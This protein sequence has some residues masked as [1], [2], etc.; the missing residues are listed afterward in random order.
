MDIVELHSRILTKDCPVLT[1]GFLFTVRSYCASFRTVQ[2]YSTQYHTPFFLS[3]F[4]WP[5]TSLL[6][7]DLMLLC[8]YFTTNKTEDWRA[9]VDGA[10]GIC[11]LF[12][13]YNQP[14]ASLQLF[15]TLGF[16]LLFF[17]SILIFFFFRREVFALTIG[18]CLS[19]TQ[20][21]L[22]FTTNTVGYE[23]KQWAMRTTTGPHQWKTSGPKAGWRAN[24]KEPSAQG[25]KE[26]GSNISREQSKIVVK[27]SCSIT[28]DKGQKCRR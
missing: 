10:V 20:S 28:D 24:R 13:E 16:F 18:A 14:R 25:K 23:N 19:E 3:L 5:L 12:W 4:F 26:R 11:R 9:Y 6:I 1:P 7:L 17:F 21:S 15:L 8:D 22:A 2:L 27:H